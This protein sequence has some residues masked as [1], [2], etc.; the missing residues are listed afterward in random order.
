MKA[1]GSVRAFFSAAN[2]QQNPLRMS[3]SLF[4]LGPP[5]SKPC[6]ALR[7]PL[8]LLP[9]TPPPAYYNDKL[10]VYVVEY[11][12]WTPLGG[13]APSTV[14]FP[15]TVSITPG[16]PWQTTLMAKDGLVSSAPIPQVIA[17][18]YAGARVRALNFFTFGGDPSA[19]GMA[20]VTINALGNC[21][22]AGKSEASITFCFAWC[23]QSAYVTEPPCSPVICGQ[24][25]PPF[26]TTTKKHCGMS[27][28]VLDTYS[29]TPAVPP[30]PLNIATAP[31]YI[32]LELAQ[33]CSAPGTDVFTV[34][35]S[36]PLTACNGSCDTCLG[37]TT[38]TKYF[39]TAPPGEPLSNV[40]TYS[41]IG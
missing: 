15:P 13:A 12:P 28:T 23:A 32:V 2:N 20:S 7:R 24:T 34:C 11:P 19:P 37:G 41:T 9:P 17:N 22:R 1:A 29:G 39:I 6:A 25:L 8:T 35:D 10:I 33:D 21:K 31:S 18:A 40:I 5:G 30:A 36:G 3:S 27:F 4:G 38:Y 16:M 14:G 26:H